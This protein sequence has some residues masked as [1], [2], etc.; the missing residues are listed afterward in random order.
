MPKA[1]TITP[2]SF[3]QKR[4][5][6]APRP[7]EPKPEPHFLSKNKR[8]THGTFTPP[9]SPAKLTIHPSTP[10]ATP[11]GATKIPMVP[12]MAPLL[13]NSQSATHGTSV[14]QNKRL[15]HEPFTPPKATPT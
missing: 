3:T 12:S 14:P 13:I 11:T 8:A 10:P 2:T 4:H 5:V 7:L 6:P 9:K 1:S 15:T